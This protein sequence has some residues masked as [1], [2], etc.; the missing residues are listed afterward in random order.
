MF[1]QKYMRNSEFIFVFYLAIYLCSHAASAVGNNITKASRNRNEKTFSLF[2]VVQFPNDVCTSTSGTYTNGSCITSS[3][4][5]S[6]G[7]AVQGSCAAGFG[8][9]CIY[10]YSDTGSVISQNVSYIV[11]PSY[12]SN[13][14]PTTTPATLSYT[15]NKCSCDV[16]RIRL[17]F[18]DFQLTAPTSASPR[19]LCTTD[20]MTM[21]TTAHTVTS[22]STGNYGNYPYLCG[23]N[24]GTHAYIDMSCTCTDT[25][26][27]DFTL[28]DS[29]SNQFKIKVTQ[30][31]CDD[32]DVASNE[33]CFQYFT[34]ETG[35]FDS[36]GLQSSSMICGHN[37]AT[38]IRPLQGYCCIEYTATTWDVGSFIPSDDIAADGGVQTNCE[39]NGASA[40][41]SCMG[42]SQCQKNFVLIPGAISELTCNGA[43]EFCY[44]PEDGLER[45]C[46]TILSAEGNVELLPGTRLGTVR[47][48]QR[49]FRVYAGTND[50]GTRANSDLPAASSG[51]GTAANVNG[52]EGITGWGFTYRQLP[53]NC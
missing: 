19:G 27:L 31:S 2:S 30:L 13:Y 51:I 20:V 5:L 40:I 37:Y 9:C 53:G 10:T 11:N 44:L 7:G 26:T 33:G 25:A 47:S 14:A 45:Y 28:G 8:V 43:S 3:E 16:C 22:S 36:F 48:C 29:T 46:G 15:I 1:K 4:C 18:E 42:G 24:A 38:C 21:K 39:N 50:C 49:P 52:D 32:P 41:T 23:T 35:S 6:R 12:P 34:G 17:D